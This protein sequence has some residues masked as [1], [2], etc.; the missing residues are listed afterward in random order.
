M[1]TPRP[2]HIG[3]YEATYAS[4]RWERPARYNFARD[5]IDRWAANAPA[6]PALF[7]VDAQGR[8]QAVT[9]EGLSRRSRQ[10]ANALAAAGVE[11]GDVVILVLG[12]DIA[13]WESMTA[14]IRMGAIASPGTTQLTPKDYAYRIQ[15][16]GAKAVITLASLAEKV[17]EIAGECPGLA[18]RFSVGGT[19]PGSGWIDYEQAVAAA[20]DAFDAVD[21]EATDPSICYF[22]S[23]T[24]RN[25]K[26]VL[27]DQISYAIGHDVTGRYWLDLSPEDLHWNISDTGWGKAAYSSFFGPLRQGATLFVDQHEAFSPIRTLELL[28]HYPITTLCGPPTVYRMLVQQDL[29]KF[30]FAPLRHC[31]GAGEPLN[32]EVI[33]QW[34]SA[35]GLPIHDG[36][37]QTETTLLCATMPGMPVKPGSM[38]RPC[39]GFD[40][41]IVNDEG[42]ILPPGTEGDIAVRV[43]PERPVGLLVEYWHDPEK[44][45]ET[46][47]GDWYITGDRGHMDED[48]YFWF[49]SRADDVI[50]SAGYRI[51]PFEV[52]SAL[53][54]H[55]AVAESAV[56]ASPDETRG[57]LVKAFIVLAPGFEASEAL[58]EDIKEHVKRVTA[59]YKYPRRIEF[60]KELPKTISGKI[61][62]VELRNQEWA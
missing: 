52:E 57:A 13:W 26:M 36:Y 31:V 20:S 41:Q 34:R 50:L 47:R 18:A 43:K 38:G 37:G 53:I 28:Q 55:A 19:L 9:Y 61:R 8:E 32:P 44:T 21:T 14:C 48:G 11:R 7:C 33:A 29:D 39:P 27:H 2:P 5:D 17:D 24:T 46:L 10:V 40:L 3:D 45:A 6:Q 22:T 35:T 51:G 60:V 15:A 59:P 54:E 4:Y 12:R 49:A 23:G 30:D 16:S 1:T 62:R 42:Q 56:V 58:A 25:P